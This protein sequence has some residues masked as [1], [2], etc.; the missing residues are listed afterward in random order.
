M[1]GFYLTLPSNSSMSYFPDNTLTNYVTR[2]PKLFDLKGEWE[3]GL[4]EIQYPHTWYN[5]PENCNM[6]ISTHNNSE[7]RH[8]EH[9]TI[10]A[11]HYKAPEL[12]KRIRQNA[13]KAMNITKD[14][15]QRIHLE[16]DEANQTFEAQLNGYVLVV[17]EHVQNLLGMETD[18][19]PNDY[20][21][22]TVSVDMDRVDSL[23]VYCDVVE[24][25]VVGDVM[26]PLLRIV[27]VRGRNGE[28]IIKSYQNVHYIPLQHKTFQT[29]EIDIRDRTGKKVPFER[30]TVNVTLHFRRRRRML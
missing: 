13:L 21:R 30:G 3:V 1:N 10:P 18:F 15:G 27:P 2:L 6:T 28:T 24:P 20:S 19:F 9:F 14:D 4:V 17:G 7:T 11:G 22:G 8:V 23:Y 29:V 5:V 25:I 12:I 26:A 16:Y